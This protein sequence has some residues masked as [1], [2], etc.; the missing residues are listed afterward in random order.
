MRAFKNGVLVKVGA[1]KRFKGSSYVP[2]GGV[3]LIPGSLVLY[4]HEVWR[5]RSTTDYARGEGAS[6][7][8]LDK[9]RM[10]RKVWCRDL[11]P[12]PHGGL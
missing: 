2:A 11:L 10:M 9:K 12:A 5:V 7:I 3:K 8:S 4:R 6:L 1:R